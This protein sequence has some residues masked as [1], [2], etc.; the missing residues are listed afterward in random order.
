MELRSPTTL[1]V[2][3]VLLGAQR[4]WEMRLSRAHIAAQGSG[5]SKADGTGNWVLM[6]AAHVIWI[7]GTGVELHLRGVVAPPPLF[8]GGGLLLLGA[9]ALR[10]WCLRSLGT[11]W[12]AR[13]VVSPT[14]RVVDRG[15]YRWLRHPNYLAVVLELLALPLMAGAWVTLLVASALNG[16]ALRNRIRGEDA[17]LRA[18]P[19]YLE[20]MGHKGG[21]LPRLR[22]RA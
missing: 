19:D 6:I 9:Q 16:V 14:L 17:L 15:P 11:M 18:L 5:A 1:Y 13:G 2:L 4:L 21:I 20:R 12:N 8:W 7:G 22:S 3:L 10:L